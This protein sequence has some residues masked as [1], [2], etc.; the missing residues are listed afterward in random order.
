KWDD[1]PFSILYPLLG[2]VVAKADA[3]EAWYDAIDPLDLQERLS[4][5]DIPTQTKTALFKAKAEWISQT[6]RRGPPPWGIGPDGELHDLPYLPNPMPRWGSLA[7]ASG[8]DPVAFQQIPYLEQL[9]L[10]VDLG[11]PPSEP[12]TFSVLGE[13]VPEIVGG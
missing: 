4:K 5:I 7:L 11:Y 6:V 3:Y 2:P 1:P 13:G 8:V 9:N 12:S 10:V